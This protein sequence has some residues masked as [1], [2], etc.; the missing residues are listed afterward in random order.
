MGYICVRDVGEY[1]L[2]QALNMASA[3]R[4]DGFQNHAE[5]RF[6]LTGPPR[7]EYRFL[8]PANWA[9]L[10]VFS[11][12][13]FLGSNGELMEITSNCSGN[14]RGRLRPVSVG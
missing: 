10:R 13:I 12:A 8:K 6:H 7:A 9:I 3:S 2:V 1:W 5:S 4:G 11:G 14:P